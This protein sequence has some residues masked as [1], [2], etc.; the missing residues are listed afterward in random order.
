MV[1]FWLYF[2]KYN[3]KSMEQRPD[4]GIS[5]LICKIPKWHIVDWEPICDNFMKV[6]LNV[7]QRKITLLKVKAI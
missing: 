5:I 1:G 7:P 4:R 2:R 6:S 3:G